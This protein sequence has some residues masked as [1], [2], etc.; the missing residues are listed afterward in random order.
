[1]QNKPPVRVGLFGIGLDTYWPQFD[2]L[3]NRL[4]GHQKQIA[5]HLRAHGVQVVDA[6][7]VDDTGKAR[8]AAS[9]FRRK[10]VEVIFLYV[11]TMRFPRP[12]CPSCKRRAC[13]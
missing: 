12:C 3:L 5:G 6:G 4:T 13:R 8:A 11:S 7:M 10:E 1:M 9:L 2:G